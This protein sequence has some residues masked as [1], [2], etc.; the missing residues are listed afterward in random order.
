MFF[1][2]IT[3]LW[4]IQSY[5]GAG[6]IQQYIQCP[7][8]WMSEMGAYTFQL[9]KEQQQYSMSRTRA[10]GKWEYFVSS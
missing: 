7:M 3:S 1:T 9:T 6:L 4:Q 5:V 10:E 2:T 8:L